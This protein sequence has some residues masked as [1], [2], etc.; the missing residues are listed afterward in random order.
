MMYRLAVYRQTRERVKVVSGLEFW[1]REVTEPESAVHS[2]HK[3]E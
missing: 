3:K 1:S 2:D